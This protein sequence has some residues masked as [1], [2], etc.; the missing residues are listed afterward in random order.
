MTGHKL[1]VWCIV[2]KKQKQRVPSLSI[3][4]IHAPAVQSRVVIREHHGRPRDTTT[5]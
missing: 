1:N 5:R 2:N 3:F 4:W